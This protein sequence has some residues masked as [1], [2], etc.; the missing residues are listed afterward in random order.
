MGYG[1]F[2]LYAMSWYDKLLPSILR[3]DT[4]SSVKSMSMLGHVGQV[5]VDNGGNIWYMS[6]LS[7]LLERND[8]KI[9]MSS[10]SGKAL[11]LRV[12]TPFATVTDRA[13]SMFS[14]GKFYVVDKNDNEH[15]MYKTRDG[16]TD[17]LY[18]RFEKM[19]RFLSRPNPL[20]SGRQFNKQVE[21]TMKAFGFCPIFTL[22]PIPGELPISMW[23]I[24]PELFHVI[25]SGKLWS[26]SDL[27]GIISEAYIEWNGE[28]INLEKDDYFIVSDSTAI[29]GGYQSELRFETTVDSL[30]KPVNNWINQMSARNTLIIDGGPKGIICDDSGGDVYGNSSLTSKEQRELNDNFKRKYGLVGKLYSIL[31]TT[32]KLKWVPITH[33]SKDLMLHEEDESCRNIISNAIGLNPNVLMPDSKFANLQEAKTAAYQD[34]IIPDSENYTEIL[35]ENIAYD[36]MRIRLDY[37]HIS[38]LQED[39]LSSAQAFSTS[40][41]SAKDLYDMGLITMQEA[42]RE[43][44]NYMDINPDDP[45]G[46]FK[47]NKEEISNE[48]QEENNREAI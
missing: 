1:S 25:L 22:R 9:D 28:R 21:M 19:R 36:G 4:R 48:S 6:G 7:S 41:T 11:A 24:P 5:D 14:N 34:L 43:I 38:C 46:D 44:A 12:C 2:Y 13:G 27:D 29:I 20:Q 10:I 8:F 18:P 26:Q 40:S 32:A 15:G 30:S 35:T 45:E 39:K 23:I 3:F 42:R 31:V 17:S 47:D 33:S 16:K 37:S